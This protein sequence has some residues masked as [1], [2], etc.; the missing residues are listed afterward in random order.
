[1]SKKILPKLQFYFP[2]DYN[3]D[4]YDNYNEDDVDNDDVAATAAVQRRCRLY[5]KFSWR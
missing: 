3:D 4:Y 1:M 5:V 2:H